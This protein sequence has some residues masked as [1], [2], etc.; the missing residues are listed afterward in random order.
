LKNFIKY[1]FGIGI[2]LSVLIAPWGMGKTVSNMPETMAAV[3]DSDSL[4]YPFQDHHADPYSGDYH[5]NPLY[6]QDPSNVK[7][8]IEYDPSD[9]QYNINQNIGNLFYRNPSYMSFDEFVDHEYKQSTRNYWRQRAGEDDKL[10]KKLF[11]PKIT[12][13][14][15]IFDRIFGGNTIDIRPQGSAELIF[16][17]N[18]SNT[19]NPALPETQRKVTTFDFK[20]N[21]QMN[22]I[23][24]IGDKLKLQANYNTGATFEFENKMKLEYNGYEDDIIRKI[25]A[26]N[27]ALPLNSQLIQGSQ[28]LFGIKTELQFGRMKVTSVF[29]QQKGKSSTINVQGGAQT[30]TFDIKADQ[31]EANKHY[32]LAQYFKNN[33]DNALHDLNHISSGVNITRL[34]V[35]VTNIGAATQTNRNI[36]AFTDLGENVPDPTQTLVSGNPGTLPENN[37]NN[38]LSI[39]PSATGI[40]TIDSLRTIANVN[41]ILNPLAAPYNY[42]EKK[43]Y[44][45]ITQAKLLS[46]SE[47]FFNPL[48]G[49]ISLN[50]ALNANQVL[51][52]AYE[53]TISGTTYHVGDLSTDGIIQGNKA[54]F[55]KLIKS[56]DFNPHS[57]TWDL[58]MKN[59][60]SLGGYNIDRKD[61]RL[62]VVYQD[63][64]IGTNINFIPQGCDSIKG[65]P[66]IKLLN[67]DQLNTNGDPQPDGL[68]DMVNGVTINLQSGKIIFPVRE[69]FGSYLREKFCV[70]DGS[71]P[72][73]YVYDALYDSTK[74]KAQQQPEKNKF[75]LRGRYQSSSGSD[76]PLNAVNVPQGS[77]KVTA[78]GAIL[79]EN[80]D[81]TVDYNLG[82]VKII[83]QGILQSNTPITINL[84]SNSLFNLQTKTMI[85]SRF[86]YYINKDFS[87]GGTILHLSERPLTQKV[88]I[89]DEPI[90]NTVWGVDG[91]Y[92]T[93]SR[94]LTKALDYL[95]LYNTKEISNVT[96]AGEFAQLI[97]GHSSAIGAGGTSYIDDFEGAVTPLDIKNPGQWY[98][99]SIPQGQPSLFPEADLNDSLP[100][101]YNRAKIAWYF[102]DPL[103]QHNIT[104]LTPPN[105]DQDDMSNNYVREIP[106]R[107]IFPNKSEPNGP[108]TLTC[109]NV[110]FYPDERGPYNYDVTPNLYSA[111]LDTA[112]G[113][114]R[115]PSTRWGGIMRKLETNDFEASN[116]E[117]IQFWVMDPFANGSPNDNTGGD[118]YFDLGSMSEDIL[119]DGQ[120]SYENGLPSITSPDAP[121]GTSQ[122]GRY[123]IN[124]S[125]TNAFDND[126]NSRSQQDVGLDGLNDNAEQSFFFNYY[127]A[128]SSFA[129]MPQS[130]KD[131]ITSDISADDYSYYQSNTYNDADVKPLER[132]KKYNGTEGNSP[133][134]P[135]VDGYNATGTN[136]PDAEDINKDNN[137]RTGEEYFQYKVHLRPDM[138]VGQDYVT[139]EITSTVQYTN[140]TT[141]SMKWYQF[142]IPITEPT[143]VVNG[144]ENFNNIEF[145]RMFMKGF[146]TPIICRFAKLELL[147]GEWRKYNAALLQPGEY[148]P[149][150]EYP[151]D[152][153]FDISSVSIEE[154]GS[155]QPIPYV[156]PPGIEKERDISTTQLS[157]L[158]EQSLS[159]K[160]C[161]LHDGDARAAFK[162]T[163]V[164]IRAYKKLKMYIHAESLEGSDALH[165]GDLTCFLRLGSDFNDNYY[166]YEIPLTITPFNTTDPTVIWPEANNMEISLDDLVNAKLT[167]DNAIRAN[168][169]TVTLLSDYRVPGTRITIKGTPNLSNVRA[170]MIG[171][172]NPQSATPGS[173]PIRCGEIWVNEL[174]LSDFDEKGGWAA[175][176]RVTSKLADLGTMTLSGFHS[177]AGWGSI[178]KRVSERDKFDKSSY[179]FSTSIELGKFLP[180]KTGIK[181]P[182]FFGYSEAV[183]TPQYNPLDP[184]VLLEQ[185]LA[186]APSDA[187][188]DDIKKNAEDY[189]ERK[190]I[191]F[192][193]VKKSKVG[194]NKKSHIYDV[195]NLNFSY[196]YTEQYQRNQEIARSFAKT[197][198]AALGYNF[199]AAPKPVTPFA[200]V[201]ALNSPLLKLIKDFNFYTSP[202]QL[203]FLVSLD[204]TYSE[205]IVRDNSG[206]FIP[207]DT[208]FAKTYFMRRQYG[209][210]HDFTKSLK[211]DFDA[212]AEAAID[213][214]YG[215]IDTREK[216]DT[217]I[218]H[219]FDLGRLKNYH[220]GARVTYN[221]PF[222]KIPLT[223]WI[224]ANASYSGDYTWT[225]GPLAL[226]SITHQ[227][228]VNPGVGNN[229]QNSRSVTINPNFNMVTLYNKIPYFKKINQEGN[230]PKNDKS[231]QPAQPPGA[232]KDSTLKTTPNVLEPV[233]KGLSNLV[234]SLKTVSFSYTQTEGTS[235]P[236]F[237]GTPDY[238]GND[239]NYHFPN[240]GPGSVNSTAP[241]WGYVSGYSQDRNTILTRAAK[242]QWLTTD[243]TLNTAFTNTELKNFSGRATIEPFKDF[244]IELTANRN[245]AIS[246]SEYFRY[247]IPNNEFESFSPTE[248]GN[249]NMSYLTI[250]TAFTNDRVDYSNA[251]FENFDRY[252]KEFSRI[253]NAQNPNA[254]H[255]PDTVN[256]DYYL[257]YG[258]TQ[259][260]VLTYAFLAA[261]SGKS[262]SNFTTNQFPKT[263][264]PNW[265]LDYKGISKMKW[266]QKY[267][268]SFTITHGYRSSYSVNSFLLNQDY[269]A[270][271]D[272]SSTTDSSIHNFIPKYTI[273]Q[274]TI[275]EQFAPL[276]G[277][278]MVWKNSLQT[279]FEYKRDRTL[280]LAYSNIQVTEIR[281]TEYT[282]GLGYKIKKFTL[283][284]VRTAG[285][286]KKL[287]SDL[288]LRAD[289]SLRDSR[290]ILRKL[291]EQTNQPSAGTQT[292]S[293]KFSADYAINER[294]NIKAFY[295]YTG[296]EPFVS[297]SYPNS[298]VNAGI[299]LRFTLAQ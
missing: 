140:G 161:N 69:P 148:S 134:P 179:D 59:V 218:R 177:T 123:P 27:V 199:N 257:G 46:P 50:V 150:P 158:N 52:V 274:V 144:I 283:P 97:P 127:N 45:T 151:G 41:A 197:H 37:S 145:I 248:S 4:R 265:R 98:L 77:V 49:F 165:N 26:G 247:S 92:R 108:T 15:I 138:I 298:N 111:G 288:N 189:T 13:N 206:L 299:S 25:E 91:T 76:I 11:A 146:D 137:M 272:Y 56:T 235:L 28:S 195:E 63:D 51:A 100:L 36:L 245:Y 83:N 103:F 255:I 125:V 267:F 43:N 293:Y 71:L 174:R 270:V 208:T 130:V 240:G 178:E 120:K 14:S 236:G 72:D 185:S 275:S 55:A 160:V 256:S 65:I 102:V 82:R 152:T 194:T 271:S 29:S 18:I 157:T 139:D 64:Q 156:L 273:S 183:I 62:D 32:F 10:N 212:R 222:N 263:P 8:T 286:K 48:L 225:A 226:D 21:I 159:L 215:R 181:I 280:T 75:S 57:Y 33:Y 34:E 196:A 209:L 61:F 20:E 241:G 211:F 204:R 172:R 42:R 282:L 141:G 9:N 136:I 74:T 31:Y 7:T 228:I 122:W 268:Q 198:Q 254:S 132:Y 129:G 95:P 1:F 30:Q 224:A 22:V 176:A 287:S 238:L 259:Q 297:S 250:N 221:V 85:G 38:L 237:F 281:G 168:P 227:F 279:R 261:Y 253:L 233:F 171:I 173:G 170:M 89:G 249:F 230:K 126:P 232:K 99:A 214:P 147:R 217:I 118:L 193:N 246:H 113:H 131:N 84:E 53:Y 294:F 109:M 234:M 90:S 162:T 213:E 207:I 81:Y 251:N 106:Q 54:L 175:T 201:K 292:L 128:I 110:A 87:V 269:H 47:Y 40:T 116:I 200:K 124:T 223:D 163:Q 191:N 205:T 6:G 192:T 242:N 239:F 93:D 184:D 202:T 180:E 142:K 117:Y 17:A 203:S 3:V 190:S 35:W 119:R 44:E 12:V 105:I 68:F 186:A 229:I 73:H 104:N 266:A 58:M 66:L 96:V 276:L 101:G 295:D 5:D 86:D 243:T 78:G 67:L 220:H 169:G 188:R 88:N 2:S 23:A 231:K 155:R 114:L 149:I 133:A 244:K 153:H 284:F 112:T 252:R 260:E 115:N 121:T 19:E 216:S 187:I 79:V 258:A 210:K 143:E 107:E 289:L 80:V 60:Y 291:V 285:G 24:N 70:T 135:Q 182:M 262:P 94:V 154:N 264:L 278:E 167:R 290:T 277:I 16:A 219:I 166:E 296:N 164:D 39:I